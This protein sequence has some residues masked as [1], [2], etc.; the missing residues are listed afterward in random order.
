MLLDKHP[1][2][3]ASIGENEVPHEVRFRAWSIGLV[4]FWVVLAD[5]GTNHAISEES[6]LG[7]HSL[8]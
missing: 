5:P 6:Q 3:T 7:C 4:M 1:I 2:F 8:R